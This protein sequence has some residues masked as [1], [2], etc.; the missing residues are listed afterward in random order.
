MAS[1]HGDA[2]FTPNPNRAIWVEGRIED[3]LLER[4]RPEILELTARSREPVTVFINS[5]G[6]MPNVAI[7]ILMALRRTTPDDARVSRIITVAAPKAWSAAANLLSAGDFA[8]A[9]PDSALLYHGGRV[10]LSGKQLTAEVAREGRALHTDHEISAS[11]LAV[12]SFQR[13]QFIFSALSPLFARHRAEAG[14]P[15]LADLDCFH[16]LLRGRL[17]PAGQRVIDLAVPLSRDYDGLFLQFRKRLRR[18]R[19]VTRTHLRKLMIYAS[20]DFEW[21]TAE[22]GDEPWDGG[23]GRIADHFYFLNAYFGDHERLLE[24]CAAQAEPQMACAD[25][26]ELERWPLRIFF[27]ALCR[28]LQEGENYIT[29]A[30]AVLLGLIDTVWEAPTTP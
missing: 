6:G 17:S 22:E 13:L 27:R 30:D 15:T 4:L 29:P 11:H 21:E 20:A 8:I 3:A 5:S 28:A 18:G 9:H 24:W 19:A 26:E 12:D 10:P 1:A 7:G 2:D 16:A 25:A 14:N 23:L